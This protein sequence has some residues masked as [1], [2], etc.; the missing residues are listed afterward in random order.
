MGFF[1][2]HCGTVIIAGL[3]F[4]AMDHYAL[5]MV[6]LFVL[7]PLVAIMVVSFRAHRGIDVVAAVF[8]SVAAVNTAQKLADPIDRMLLDF[9]RFNRRKNNEKKCFGTTETSNSTKKQQ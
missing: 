1:S 7:L 5:G 9:N 8:A 3:E 4:L 2:G 6:H